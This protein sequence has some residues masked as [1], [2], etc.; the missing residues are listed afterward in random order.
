MTPFNIRKRLKTALGMTPTVGDERCS[1]TFVL[2]N[3][4]ERTVT[5]EKH[6]TLLMAAD[7]NG[8]TI[9]HRR[10]GARGPSER[11]GR[12]AGAEHPAGLS[13]QGDG[14]RRQDQDPRAL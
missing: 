6:Y 13:R 1:V 11:A 2:P 10:K 7:A 12:G 8:L 5:C 4:T 3:G 14:R 9:S